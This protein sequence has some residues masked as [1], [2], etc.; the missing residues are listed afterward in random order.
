MNTQIELDKEL[1]LIF[2]KGAA[3]GIAGAILVQFQVKVLWFSKPYTCLMEALITKPQI[4]RKNI[5]VRVLNG[6]L[7]PS[8]TNGDLDDLLEYHK[9]SIWKGFKWEIYCLTE[10]ITESMEY[11]DYRYILLPL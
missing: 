11:S 7:H 1:A 4:N 9:L 8:F 10:H 2:I 6:H 5:T 3:K